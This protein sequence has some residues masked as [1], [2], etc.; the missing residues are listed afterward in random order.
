MVAGAALL[1]GSAIYCATQEWKCCVLFY[2][3]YCILY[4]VYCI[5]YSVLEPSGVV[6]S[7][8]GPKSQTVQSHGELGGELQ[9]CEGLCTQLMLLK[10]LAVVI[11]RPRADQPGCYTSSFVTD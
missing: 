10:C 6:T 3:V 2:T 9:H 8:A 4:S 1:G 7:A 5:L 11:K